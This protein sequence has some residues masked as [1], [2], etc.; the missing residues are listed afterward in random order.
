MEWQE[1]DDLVDTTYAA[2]SE[3]HGSEQIATKQA[4]RVIGYFL[5]RNRPENVLEVGAGLGTIT[6]F[7]NSINKRYSTYYALERNSWCQSQMRHQ[8][9]FQF[10]HLIDSFDKIPESTTFEFVI[11]DDLTSHSDIQ[12]IVRCLCREFV[13]VIEGHRYPQRF[14][15]I[16]YLGKL[17]IPFRYISIGKSK[18]SYKGACVIL[19]NEASIYKKLNLYHSLL[20]VRLGLLYMK[21]R[22]I[23]ARIPIR[24]IFGLR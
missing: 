20:R 5:N 23:R 14:A 19:S 2:F 6:S 16:S 7:A 17:S 8:S 11:I 9:F 22:E 4:L 1:I 21:F 18:D 13:I 12:K 10:I 3:K 24:K 15:L